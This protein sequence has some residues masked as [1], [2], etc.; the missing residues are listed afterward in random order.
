MPGRRRPGARESSLAPLTPTPPPD[1]G[2]PSGPADSGVPLYE[3]CWFRGA[4]AVVALL[5]AVAALVGVPKLWDVVAGIFNPDLPRNNTEIVLDASSGM[6]DPFEAA[7]TKLAAAKRAVGDS[8]A[9]FTNQGLALRRIGGEC[10]RAGSNSL[11]SGRSA[12]TR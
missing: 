3:R 1:S 8:V 2:G 7:P 4:A 5:A 12:P 6:S 10:T 11:T 9:P